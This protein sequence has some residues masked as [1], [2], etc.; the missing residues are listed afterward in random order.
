MRR[1][2]VGSVLMAAAVLGGGTTVAMA[3]T[4][5]APNACVIRAD[6]P[7]AANDAIVGREGCSNRIP[8]TG[9]IVESRL[10]LPDDVVGERYKGNSGTMWVYGSCGNG[11]GNYFSE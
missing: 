9:R 6:V 4:E 1:P 7:N 3:E 10:F 8:G 2:F 11:V 5:S